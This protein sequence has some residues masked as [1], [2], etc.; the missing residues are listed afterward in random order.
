MNPVRLFTDTNCDLPKDVRHEHQIGL[1]NFSIYL[2][3]KEISLDPDWRTIKP[4][5][6]YD[7]LRNGGRVYILSTTDFEIEKKFRRHLLRG[8]DVLYVGAC[9]KQSRTLAKAER[10]AEKLRIEFPEQRVEIIDSLNASVGQGF[11]VMK[12]AECLQAGMELDEVI[13]QTKAMRNNVIEFCTVE[14]LTYL[15]KANRVDARAA[16]FGN[17][18]NI[19]PIIISDAEGNQTSIMK[20]KG[21]Q[22][23]LDKIAELFLEN[24]IDPENQEVYITHG[25]DIDAAEYVKKKL[26][27]S[28]VKFKKINVQVVGAI[29]GVSTGPGMVAIFGMGKEVTYKEK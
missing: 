5:E 12:A 4:S 13:E 26:L 9:G 20:V 21:R 3:D 25:D 10:I 27:D 18:F 17:L 24:V 11:V 19:K 2:N 7:T 16:M 1:I 8:E 15:S 22:A 6:L 29:I 28:G 14:T 23:A